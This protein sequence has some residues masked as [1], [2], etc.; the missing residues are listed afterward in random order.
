M[1]NLAKLINNGIEIAEFSIENDNRENLQRKR[2]FNKDRQG[3]GRNDKYKNK[4]ET[5]IKE[6]MAS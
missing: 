5:S 6:L 1:K 3:H 4:R 2:E